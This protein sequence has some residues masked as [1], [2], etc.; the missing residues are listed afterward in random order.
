MTDV[1]GQAEGDLPAIMGM[2]RLPESKIWSWQFTQEKPRSPAPTRE[3][4]VVGNSVSLRLSARTDNLITGNATESHFA[5][6]LKTAIFG[7]L[8]ERDVSYFSHSQ[9][10][11]HV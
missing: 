9:D 3:V 1:R 6:D 8:R 5:L 7:P 10:S 2:T 11:I 4:L